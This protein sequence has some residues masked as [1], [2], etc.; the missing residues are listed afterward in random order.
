MST[1]RANW[2]RF[3]SSKAVDLRSRQS[4][5]L[6][7][8][9]RLHTDSRLQNK[10]WSQAL[11]TDSHKSHHPNLTIHLNLYCLYPNGRS[12]TMYRHPSSGIRSRCLDRSAG[13]R[14]PRRTF[15][16]SKAVLSQRSRTSSDIHDCFFI[17]ADVELAGRWTV[18]PG[19]FELWSHT[20]GI[21]LLADVFAD[22]GMGFVMGLLDLSMAL[23]TVVRS[24]MR[25]SS[26]RHWGMV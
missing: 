23:G 6:Y 8:R 19:S 13:H 5:R 4:R 12:P 26:I 21:A 16:F 17:W 14:L 22:C 25:D 15:L 9:I 2:E 11:L 1:A 18:R 10:D 20:V 24:V 7:G 3:R